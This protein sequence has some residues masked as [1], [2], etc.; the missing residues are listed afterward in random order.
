LRQPSP[1]SIASPCVGICCVGD[2]GVC[3]GCFRS[4]AELTAWPTA[5]DADKLAILRNC[6]E[7][8]RRSAEPRR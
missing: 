7:R 2:D 5:S 3:I 4:V 1:D 6:R 8:Q